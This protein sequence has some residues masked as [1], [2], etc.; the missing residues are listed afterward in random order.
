M[1]ADHR[2]AIALYARHFGRAA[3]DGW[4]V[5]GFDADGMDLAAPDATCR[6]FFPQPLQAARELRSVLVEMAKTGRAAEQER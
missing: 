1:N 6:I 5:T 3:G 2:D 4:T